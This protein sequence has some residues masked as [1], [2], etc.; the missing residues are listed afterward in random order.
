ME[1]HLFGGPWTEIKLDAVEYY[2]RFYTSALKFRSMRLWY[3][4]AFAGTGERVVEKEVGGLLEGK[5]IETE[6]E[7]LAGSAKRALGVSPP[8]QD[9]VFIEKDPQRCAA[10]HALQDLYKERRIQIRQGDAN[11]ELVHLFNSPP[12]ASQNGANGPNRGVVFLDPYAMTVPW[13]TLSLLAKT[14]SVDIWYLFPLNAALRQLAHDYKAVDASKAASLDRI[15]GTSTWRTELYSTH[16]QGNFF[17]LIEDSKRSVTGSGLE[18]WFKAR[19]ET[20]FRY[21]S[22]PL[23]LLS[24]NGAQLF[25]LFFAMANP[26]DKAI[27][28]AKNCMKDLTKKYA[29]PASRRRSAP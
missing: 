4:D 5:F 6:F 14:Q 29:V 11:E 1:G 26:S 25:S 24:P 20:E 28:L 16:R 12:W 17:D 3:I 10:L 27:G 23:P 13:S 15:F 21:V 9:F 19:L 7:T 22:T 18:A 2:L 8:F